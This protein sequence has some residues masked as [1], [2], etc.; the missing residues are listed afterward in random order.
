MRK[1]AAG[2]IVGT[3]L[4]YVDDILVCSKRPEN[5]LKELAGLVDISDSETTCDQATPQWQ[6][7]G[8]DMKFERNESGAL[9]GCRV[10]QRPVVVCSC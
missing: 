4:I 1:D 10:S 3:A 8:R 9:A 7:V 2:T 5:D 6:F